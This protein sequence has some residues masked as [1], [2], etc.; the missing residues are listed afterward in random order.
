M[1]SNPYPVRNLGLTRAEIEQERKAFIEKWNRKNQEMDTEWAAMKEKYRKQTEEARAKARA[2]KPMPPALSRFM[3]AAK[4]LQ[5][6]SSI[7]PQGEAQAPQ[8]GPTKPSARTTFTRNELTTQ[9]RPGAP[10]SR[11]AV[12]TE[13]GRPQA[14]TGNTPRYPYEEQI[15]ASYP[16]TVESSP[17]LT[18]E[19]IEAQRYSQTYSEPLA[20][21]GI[22]A[23][24]L[25]RGTF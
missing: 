15:R 21:E 22:R 14:T 2:Q 4:V 20:M 13:G 16:R 19:E 5:T 18:S 3:R 8:P 7:L 17:F 9:P 1:P 24:S 23:Q 6:I 12:A 25:W 11:P 10:E